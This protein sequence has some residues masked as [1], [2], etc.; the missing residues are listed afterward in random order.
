MHD[1]RTTCVCSPPPLSPI[2]VVPF[3]LYKGDNKYN[4]CVRNFQW[5]YQFWPIESISIYQLFTKLHKALYIEN[6]IKLNLFT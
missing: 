2:I 4:S 6:V 3:I 1:I 5:P